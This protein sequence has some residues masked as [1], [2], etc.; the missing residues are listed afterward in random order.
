M[1]TIRLLILSS[2][3]L[4][5]VACADLPPNHPTSQPEARAIAAALEAW[6]AAGR[7]AGDFVEL[8]PERARVA[9]LP[10]RE[11]LDRCLACYPGPEC[12][13]VHSC[14]YLPNRTAFERPS[15]FVLVSSAV[16]DRI[17][18]VIHETLHALRGLVVQKLLERGDP[19]PTWAVQGE[20]G[21]AGDLPDRQHLDVE[22]WGPIEADAIRRWGGVQ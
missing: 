16:D 1:D 5:A 17:P 6:R 20:N 15:L 13:N 3:L 4:F 14:V 12:R 10:P 22:L 11:V 8:D 2:V 18:L 7:P 9:V 19:L 21:A